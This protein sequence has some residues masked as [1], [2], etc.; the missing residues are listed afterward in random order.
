MEAWRKHA[1]RALLLIDAVHTCTAHGQYPLFDNVGHLSTFNEAR[2]F[3]RLHKSLVQIKFYVD[4][5]GRVFGERER[6]LSPPFL[7]LIDFVR[8]IDLNQFFELFRY[9]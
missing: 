3:D 6:F 7:F 2:H 9:F 8:K 5:E 1:R 4:A